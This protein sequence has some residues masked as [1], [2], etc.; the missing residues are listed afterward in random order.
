MF[1]H[2]SSDASGGFRRP[3]SILGAGQGALEI[4]F[5]TVGSGTRMLSQRAV[6][7]RLS[8]I[9]PIG[10]PF[11]PDP[12]ATWILAVGGGTGIPPLIFLLERLVALKTRSH[13]AFFGG[14]ELPFPFETHPRH[15]SF[16]AV[17]PPASRSLA[18]LDRIGVPSALASRA[19]LPGTYP[20][21]VTDLFSRWLAQKSFTNRDR[22]QVFSCGPKPLMATVQEIARGRGFGGA[23]CL[24]ENMACAVGGCAGCAVPIREPGGLAMRRVCVDGPV[25]PI[26]RVIFGDGV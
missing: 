12:E 8:A 23:L 18:R 24:E 9:G 10:T 13:L 15:T 3:M 11:E 1:I 7:T 20:G 2:L 14:S 16:P 21:Y 17:D 19:S 5:K 6:G 25:F 26:E 22:C 4:L